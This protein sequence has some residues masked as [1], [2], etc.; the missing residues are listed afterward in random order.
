MDRERKSQDKT[1]SKLEAQ[2]HTAQSSVHC[3]RQRL[4]RSK[5]K[6][7]ATTSETLDLQTQLLDMEDFCSKVAALEEKIDLL[8]TEVEVARHE[9]DI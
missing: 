6:V 5:D 9:R 7:E 8:V 4:Y 1:I 3:L 2:L